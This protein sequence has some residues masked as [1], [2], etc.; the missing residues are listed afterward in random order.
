M[1]ANNSTVFQKIDRT[2]VSVIKTISYISAVCLVII[3]L[4]AFLNV[5]GEKLAKAGVPFVSGIPMSMALIQYFHIPVVFLASAFVTL[6][7]GH[8]AI[9]MLSSKFPKAV[10]KFFIVLGHALGAAI[11]LFIS[12]RAFFVL[13]VRFYE[14]KSP[15]TSQTSVVAWPKWPFAFV[16]GLGFLLL[17]IS[18]IWAIVRVFA[19]PEPEGPEEIKFAE[20]V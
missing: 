5:V 2:L 7:R 18:F 14:T 19:D 16:H 15:I 8:T 9:D 6:D 1:D 10:Q 12:Y 3:M 17:G 13:M 20:E 11:T 4:I